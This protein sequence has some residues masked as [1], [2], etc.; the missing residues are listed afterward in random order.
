MCGYQR[1]VLGA[2]SSAMLSRGRGVEVRLPCLVTGT[3]TG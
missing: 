1:K 3:F 2:I